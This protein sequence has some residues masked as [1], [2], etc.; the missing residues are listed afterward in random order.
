MDN[1]VFSP[2]SKEQENFLT[3]DDIDFAFY[4]GG[5]TRLRSKPI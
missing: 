4:G 1:I 3:C 2:A 5:H